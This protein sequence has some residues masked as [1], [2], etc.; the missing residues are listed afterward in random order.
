[1]SG[2]C[3][4]WAG[5]LARCAADSKLAQH[6]TMRCLGVLSG[7]T[8]R[9][10]WVQTHSAGRDLGGNTETLSLCLGKGSKTGGEEDGGELHCEGCE[11]EDWIVVDG[12][13]VKLWCFVLFCANCVEKS[14]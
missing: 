13:G 11:N 14:W 5:W 7:E 9:A 4:G 2:G 12:S 1:M 6:R 8:K 10:R 3:D